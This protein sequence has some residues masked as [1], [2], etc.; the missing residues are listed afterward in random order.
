MFDKNIK[1]DGKWFDIAKSIVLLSFFCII[2]YLGYDYTQSQKK[3]NQDMV[4]QIVYL[5]NSSV[6]VVGNSPDTQ[7]FNDLKKQLER[8]NNELLKEIEKQKKITKET[9][10]EIGVIKAEVIQTR[11]LYEASTKVYAKPNMDEHHYFYKEVTIKNNENKEAKVAWVMFYPN[12][13][14]DKQWKV[15]TFPL[16]S[17]TTVIETENKNGTYNRYAEVIIKDKNGEKIPVKL[18]PIKWEK[19]KL[20]EKSFFWFDP[21][22]ALSGGVSSN[23]HLGVNVNLMSYGRTEIN[24]DFRF[25]TFGLSLYDDKNISVSFEPFSWNMKSILPPVHNVFV[26]PSIFLVEDG[27]K[28]GVQF[29]VP[30]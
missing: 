16:S 2:I 12:Q 17:T 21:I 19:V 20:K 22:F 24:S 26:G 25:A 23:L 30:F 4:E 9:L 10:D 6:G 11:K 27:L 13:P 1:Q 14:E 29:S 18:S 5:T 7:A 8:E 3:F 15:G 28:Y